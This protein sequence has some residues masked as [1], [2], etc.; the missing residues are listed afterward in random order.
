MVT[1]LNPKYKISFTI[2]KI[3]LSDIRKRIQRLN[4]SI[5][6]KTNSYLA[7]INGFNKEFGAIKFASS[8]GAKQY[9]IGDCA[10]PLLYK[11][12]GYPQ[13]FDTVVYFHYFSKAVSVV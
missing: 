6:C 11:I 13:K 9:C 12:S 10:S 4:Q 1:T 2:V 5:K 3:N 7:K 8:S